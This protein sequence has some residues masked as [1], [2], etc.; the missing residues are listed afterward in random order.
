MNEEFSAF[1]G[2]LLLDQA[3]YINQA[4]AY[5]L[6]LYTESSLADFPRPTSVVLVGHSM[7]GIV[8]RTIFLQSNYRQGS[9]NTIVTIATPHMAAPIS[10]DSQLTNIYARIEDFWRTAY[11]SAD[12]GLL[13]DVSLVSIMGG[14]LDITVNSDAG[15]VQHIV[16]PSNGFSV[17]TSSIPHAWVGCDHL[18]ILWCN[19]VAKAIGRAMVEI[20]DAKLAGQVKHLNHRMSIFR[21]VLITGSKILREGARGK[22]EN[23]HGSGVLASGN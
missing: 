11:Q 10:L 13:G 2:H 5:I 18:S 7:G 23:S 1:H 12:G 21:K 3:Q 22:F 8:A 6:S 19:Q 9:V 4:I 16:P 14:N 20:V 17:F 15:N